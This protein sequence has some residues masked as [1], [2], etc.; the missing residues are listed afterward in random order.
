MSKQ[1]KT[2]KPKITSSDRGD[3]SVRVRHREYLFDLIATSDWSVTPVAINP[4]LPTFAWLS[5]LA[6][7]Y[8]SYLFTSLSFDFESTASTTSA[9]TVMMAI[10]FDSADEIPV[11][12]QALMAMQGAVRTAPWQAMKYSATS[13]N[14]K[15]FG[16]QRYVRQGALNPNL[17]IKTYDVGKLLL[18]VQGAP[19]AQWG[20]VYV[21]YDI[22]FFTPQGGPGPAEFNSAN[23]F[24]NVGTIPT[25]PFGASAQ[26]KG[27]LPCRYK[28]GNT[29]RIDKVG[30]YLLNFQITG[31]GIDDS[32][33]VTINVSEP[34][35]GS[36]D[37]LD[38]LKANGAATQGS[39]LVRCRVLVP[40]LFYFTFSFPQSTSIS[41]TVL[42]ISTYKYSLD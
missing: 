42:R 9:G 22:T 20:E 14:L 2:G 30:E 34:S 28:D 1:T 32:D 35:H 16:V 29:F 27:G 37:V 7:L 38:F 23:V 8:E 10:D 19:G 36:V 21:S 17:D 18:A 15:K 25:Q 24:F 12:K 39:F 11:S 31:V 13:S 33:A 6:G 41:A 40:D 4:G 26:I 5:E 3:G